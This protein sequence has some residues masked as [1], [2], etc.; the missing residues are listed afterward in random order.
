MSAQGMNVAQLIADLIIL[1]A[2]SLVCLDCR[3]CGAVVIG[4]VE[5]ETPE[6]SPGTVW[7][8]EEV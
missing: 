3:R 6:Y 7:I 2:D 4:D 8:A 1:P 5:V